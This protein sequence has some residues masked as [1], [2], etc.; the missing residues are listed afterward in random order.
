[1]G[2]EE[3]AM[4]TA[5]ENLNVKIDAEDKRLFVELARQMGTTPSNAVRMF[6]RA[7]NDFKGFPFDTS[8]PYGMTAEARRAYEEAD[9]EIAAGTAKRYRSV[10]DLRNDLGL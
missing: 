1:M 3:E 7:F 8:R 2:D 9:A 4:S 10:A 6:V 5:M